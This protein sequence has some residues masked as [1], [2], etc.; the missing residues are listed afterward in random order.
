MKITDMK[1]R[2]TK[3]QIEILAAKASDPEPVWDFVG[4][5]PFG[6]TLPDNLAN[7]AMDARLYGW[8]KSIVD[9]IR[10]G[11]KMAVY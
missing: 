10:E 3:E 2:P 4:S 9:A 7:L 6:S 11:I 5:L 1:T 8:D